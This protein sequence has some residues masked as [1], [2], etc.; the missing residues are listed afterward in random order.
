M[1]RIFGPP[2]QNGFVVENLIA[3]A[4]YWIDVNGAG[5]FFV[6][7]H[8]RFEYF[9]YHG[10]ATAPDISLAIGYLGDL[11]V[12]LIQQHNQEPSPYLTFGSAKGDGLH[13]IS[14]WTTDYEQT[15]AGLATSGRIPDCEGRIVGASRFAYFNSD[16]LDG[17][18]FEVSDL[19]PSNEFGLLHEFARD[20]S[21]GW[22]GS[23]PIREIG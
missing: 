3:A 12:E 11:E 17:S 18:A 1:S 22:D 21:I 5:P 9:R 10:Q 15:L 8:L 14:S 20:A 7:R 23:E 19:G 16:A 6:L 13:H 4:R 2:K